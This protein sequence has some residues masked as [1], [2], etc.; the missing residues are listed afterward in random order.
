VADENK[1]TGPGQTLYADFEFAVDWRVIKVGLRRTFKRT[2][3]R[4]ELF[5]IQHFTITL[6]FQDIL[7]HQCKYS[8]EV[9]SLLSCAEL[10]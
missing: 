1:D 3:R 5:R 9:S 8:L 10:Q 6:D 4:L 7:L 2:T